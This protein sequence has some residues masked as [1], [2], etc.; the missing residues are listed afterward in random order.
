MKTDIEMRMMVSDAIVAAI[1]PLTKEVPLPIFLMCFTEM[2]ACIIAD[3]VA[4]EADEEKGLVLVHDLVKD[5]LTKI[6]DGNAQIFGNRS[7]H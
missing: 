5:N 2:M 3:A 7:I 1:N 6:K 4:N